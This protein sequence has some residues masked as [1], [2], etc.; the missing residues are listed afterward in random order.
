MLQL[1]GSAVGGGGG[2][3]GSCYTLF[4][5]AQDYPDFLWIQI[6]TTHVCDMVTSAALYHI[7][8]VSHL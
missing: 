2:G 5:H 8:L 7:I 1:A 6:L 4:K 3:G